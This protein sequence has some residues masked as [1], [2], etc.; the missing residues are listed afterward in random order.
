MAVAQHPESKR[1][2]EWID[3]HVEVPPVDFEKLSD[4][5]PSGSGS[6]SGGAVG[7]HPLHHFIVDFYCHARR[8]V[9][10]IDGGIHEEHQEHDKARNRWFTERG[11]RM[12]R[13]TNAQVTS[14]LQQVSLEIDRACGV[15]QSPAIDRIRFPPVGVRGANPTCLTAHPVPPTGGLGGRLRVVLQVLTRDE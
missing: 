13:F 15:E 4:W 12:L 6:P 8:L 10:E 7:G 3:I 2:A 14:N 9:I 1:R 5:E 11:F